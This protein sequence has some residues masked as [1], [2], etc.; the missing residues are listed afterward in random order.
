VS[1]PLS[2]VQAFPNQDP[3]IYNSVRDRI[4]TR[5][6]YSVPEDKA[7]Y[8]GR[9]GVYW[10]WMPAFI[11]GESGYGGMSTTTGAPVGT[12]AEE[13][14]LKVGGGPLYADNDPGIP[15]QGMSQGGTA[16]S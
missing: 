5:G 15:T 14:T 1:V 2:G 8:N 3:G 13:D 10:N 4:T 12:P 11:A 6:A 9:A 7:V 16:A